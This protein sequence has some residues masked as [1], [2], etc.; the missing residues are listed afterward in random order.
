MA[1]RRRTFRRPAKVCLVFCKDC[2]KDDA[3]L[4]TQYGE[5]NEGL[6]A[7]DSCRSTAAEHE[8]ETAHEVEV[9]T[10]RKDSIVIGPF[11]KKE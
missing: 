2:K 9:I 6:S 1:I 10:Y 5:D 11:R 8:K 3:V 7:F 4:Q